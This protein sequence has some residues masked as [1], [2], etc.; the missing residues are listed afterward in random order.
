MQ[1]IQLPDFYYLDNF[2][3][4]LDHVFEYNKA[5]LREEDF[6]DF[7][8]FKSLSKNAQATFTRFLMRKGNYFRPGKIS[9]KEI[10][11]IDECIDELEGVNFISWDVPNEEKI[12]LFTKPELCDLYPDVKL[13]SLPRAEIDEVLIDRVEQISERVLALEKDFFVF[14]L[15]YFGNAHQDLSEFILND[16]GIYQYENYSLSQG[17]IKS[18]EEL[19]EFLNFYESITQYNSDQPLSFWKI[20]RS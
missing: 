12:K 16:L 10:P 15:L 7:L 11:N 20:T 9:Y 8:D 1:K 2:I 14:R 19:N 17:F 3:Q 13:K 18:E 4:L 6:D 5:V